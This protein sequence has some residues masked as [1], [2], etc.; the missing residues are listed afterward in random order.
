MLLRIAKQ[1]GLEP[2]V[3]PGFKT[4]GRGARRRGG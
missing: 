3:H 4:L 2:G 1:Q